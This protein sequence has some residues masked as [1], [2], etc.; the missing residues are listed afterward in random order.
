MRFSHTAGV[1]AAVE[2]SRFE[3]MLYRATRGNCFYQFMD[4]DQPLTDPVPKR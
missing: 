4:I 3:R 2:R 1:V